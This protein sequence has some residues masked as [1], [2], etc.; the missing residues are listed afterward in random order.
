MALAVGLQSLLGRTTA[1][2]SPIK[3]GY[4]LGVRISMV[5]LDCPGQLNGMY[6]YILA[7]VHHYSTPER[8]WVS[9]GRRHNECGE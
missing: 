4:T 8:W 7:V 9:T 6:V 2:Q 1:S 5:S 3:G